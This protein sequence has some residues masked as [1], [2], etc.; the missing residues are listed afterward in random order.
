MQ[1]KIRRKSHI[2]VVTD[3]SFHSSRGLKQHQRSCQSINNTPA[4]RE[5]TETIEDAQF[6]TKISKSVDEPSAKSV[7]YIWGKYK[8]HEF[9]KNLSQVYETIVLWRKN[10]P[11]TISESGKKVYQRSFKIIE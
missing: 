5:S 7:K 6:S 1:A 3:R 8:D 2:Y 11:V 10:V 9:E 4:D